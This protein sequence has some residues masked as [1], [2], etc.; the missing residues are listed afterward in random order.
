MRKQFVKTIE[1]ILPEDE[2]LVLLLG[3]IGI[4]GFRN[5]FKE[6]PDRVFNIGI[7][8]QSTISLGSGM[9]SIGLI[10]VIHTIAPFLVERSLEQLKVDFGYQKFNGNFITVGSSYDYAALGPTHHCPG[11]VGQLSTIP[12]MEIV[13]PGTSE[14]FDKLFKESYNDGNPTYFRLSEYENKTSQDVKFGKANLIK[15]GNKALIVCVGNMLQNTIEATE[16]LDVSILY[17]TTLSPFDY[18]SLIENFNEKIIVIEPYYEGGLNYK[19]NKALEN[20]KYSLSNIGVP[21][22]FL[23]NYGTKY[24]H[25]INLELDVQGIKNKILKCI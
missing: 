1:D 23:T 14:E 16:D 21:H 13:L 19:I 7:L 20:K 11:D 2:N 15:K 8:E 6:F 12:T 24:E 3:D 17:Y 4:F 22:R 25:D 18:K 10:P 5:S 9:S